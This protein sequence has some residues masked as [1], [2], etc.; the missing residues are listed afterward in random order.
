RTQA[1][2]RRRFRRRRSRPLLAATALLLVVSGV[3]GLAAMR[4]AHGLTAAEGSAYP[5]LIGLHLARAISDD[6][7]TNE[8]LSLIAHG[9][10]DAFDQA[11][12]AETRR[13]VDRPLTDGT[14]G[15][16]AR[17]HVAFGGPR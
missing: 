1:F 11:F 9:N 4:T 2:L 6:A 15:D 13:L 16:A 17:G 14:I 5:R 3:Q 8:S 7:D 12:T 10:G